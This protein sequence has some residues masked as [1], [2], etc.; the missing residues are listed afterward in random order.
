MLVPCDL[1]LDPM[2]F[3]YEL[4]LM[5]LETFV[6]TNNKLLGH[7]AFESYKSIK[8]DTQTDTTENIMNSAS[9]TSSSAIAERPRCRVG[10]LWPKV[11]D[12]ILQI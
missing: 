5:I 8:T 12:D 10:Q 6:H 3:I 1:D 9:L 4:D 2:T 7:E 11:E